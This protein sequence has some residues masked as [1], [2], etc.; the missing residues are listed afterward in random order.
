MTE[1]K[2][3][4]VAVVYGGRSS[5][6]SVSCISAGA[7]M[8]HL[9]PAKYDVVPIGITREGTWTQGTREGLEIVHGRMPEVELHDELALSLNPATRGR[10]HNVTRHEHYTEV[11]VIV[12]VLHGPFGED[13]TVQG[14][15]ELS[16]I[17]Y[18]GA[19]VLAS[20]VGMDK[21]F[22][23]KLLVA[24]GLPV[25][26]QEVLTGETALD[27]VQKDRLGLPV[28]VKPARGGSSIGVSKV[29]KWEDFEAAVKLAY[30]SDDKVLVEPEICGAEVEV[31]VLEHPDG[32]LQASV[33]AK[34]LGTTESEEGFYGFDAKY[35]DEGVSAEIPAPLSEELTSEIRERAI[36]AFRALG[37][38]GLSRVDFFIT[39]D[40]YY[41]NEVN[42]FPGFTPISMYP[43][44]FAAGGVSYAELLDTLIRT[45][46]SRG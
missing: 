25:A 38:A 16:G 24:E 31:G 42:T 35:L 28:F 18:V 23:K 40:T 8:E 27:D 34:L 5:E 20:A 43:Q 44:V 39:E 41:I 6:H 37:A 21:E 2:P 11:D 10:I 30:E 12:P 7:I 1:A 17:P 33:P 4:R 32:T 15:F 46:L 26:P 29:S 45:A 19:G 13:G 36:E 9:D 3:V 22:T 14:L